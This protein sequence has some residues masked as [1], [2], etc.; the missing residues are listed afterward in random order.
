MYINIGNLYIFI[1]KIY[2]YIAR[3][4]K[5]YPCLRAGCIYMI[6]VSIFD[7]RTLVICP[8][9]KLRFNIQA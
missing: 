4:S 2:K 9:N 8:V 3:I 7:D 6:R 1:D 5:R